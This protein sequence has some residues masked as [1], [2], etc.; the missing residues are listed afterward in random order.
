MSDDFTIFC[1]NAAAMGLGSI[2]AI[3]LGKRGVFLVPHKAGKSEKEPDAVI[4]SIPITLWLI[5]HSLALKPLV[6]PIISTGLTAPNPG[7]LSQTTLA[8]IASIGAGL[9][10]GAYHRNKA[11][12]LPSILLFCCLLAF[13][14]ILPSLIET[15]TAIGLTQPVAR[16][17]VLTHS[18]LGCL[19]LVAAILAHDL[20]RKIQHG[21][22]KVYADQ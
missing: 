7:L 6:P 13:S 10:I 19:S 18:G 20:I 1:V 22:R 15:T 3:M 4:I 16:L 11:S 17:Q 2:A 21:L 14:L 8:L 9:W 12:E 5:G